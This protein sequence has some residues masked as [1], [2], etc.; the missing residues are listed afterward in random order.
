M[1]KLSII[2]TVLG[3]IALI[4][5]ILSPWLQVTIYRTD[6]P[7]IVSLDVIYRPLIFWID[8]SLGIPMIIIIF[9]SM[10]LALVG[11][12]KSQEKYIFYSSMLVLLSIV[13]FISYII[14]FVPNSVIIELSQLKAKY[15]VDFSASIQI[16]I[17]PIIA[18]FSSILSAL[19]AIVENI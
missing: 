11:L 12:R 8:L 6:N 19:V 1:K 5:S 18:V 16:L 14:V 9:L 17:G 15:G 2:F 13:F 4:I 10:Y 7:A 3:I